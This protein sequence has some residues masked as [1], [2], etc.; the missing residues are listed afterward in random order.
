MKRNFQLLLN[1]IFFFFF[2]GSYTVTIWSSNSAFFVYKYIYTKTICSILSYSLQAFLLFSLLFT[3]YCTLWLKKWW[4]CILLYCIVFLKT[5]ANQGWL[6]I[7]NYSALPSIALLLLYQLYRRTEK[8][9]LLKHLLNIAVGIANCSFIMFDKKWY[10]WVF[11]CKTGME[12]L[13]R[14]WIQMQHQSRRYFLKR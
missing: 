7:E 14:F 12:D 10:F 11:L 3:I 9:H 5:S 8:E 4:Y 13:I 2:F 6:I 1:W